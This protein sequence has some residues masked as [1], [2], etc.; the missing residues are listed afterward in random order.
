MSLYHLI[1]LFSLFGIEISCTA[2][3]HAFTISLVS[4]ITVNVILCYFS[5]TLSLSLLA[6][7]LL[8]LTVC[9]QG[10]LA[11]LLLL[12]VHQFP[13]AFFFHSLFGLVGSILLFLRLALCPAHFV[14]GVH[15]LGPFFLV[16][17]TT[18]TTI[19]E[20]SPMGDGPSSM[21]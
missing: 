14:V 17:V 21:G 1:N 2:D 15:P 12:M 16:P 13:F 11:V 19:T 18:D 10:L 20:H 9:T 4:G 6:L 8:V 7:Q 5:T 3:V